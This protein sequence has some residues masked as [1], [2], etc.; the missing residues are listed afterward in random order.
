MRRFFSTR[1]DREID[2]DSGDEE[3]SSD[4]DVR[5][6]VSMHGRLTVLETKV[7]IQEL[8]HIDEGE[9]ETL[10]SRQLQ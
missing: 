1:T 4:D 6:R 10:P 9:G 8:A 5:S 2:Q 3:A 7:V